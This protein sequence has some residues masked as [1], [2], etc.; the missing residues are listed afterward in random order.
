MKHIW[1]KKDEKITEK[2]FMRSLTVSVLGILLCLV[3]LC[4]MTYAWFSADAVSPVNTLTSGTFDIAVAVA[5]GSGAAVTLSEDADGVWRGTLA[6][7]GTYTVTLT[8]TDNANVKGYCTVSA[9]GDEWQTAS[10]VP[11]SAPFTFTV[12]TTEQ[13]TELSFSPRWGLPASSAIVQDGSLTVPAAQ[14][15]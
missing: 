15:E 8:M 11:S 5:D 7:V 4:S 12:T 3:L 2:A 14:G 13:N 6:E 1:N 10:M 9:N